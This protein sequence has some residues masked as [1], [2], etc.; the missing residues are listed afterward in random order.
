[1]KE[2]YNA[3]IKQEFLASKDMNIAKNILTIF[4]SS[5]SLESYLQKDLFDFNYNEYITF[6]EKSSYV[7]ASKIA[8]AKSIIK[9]YIKWAS[10]KYYCSGNSIIEIE[11]VKNSDISGYYMS[12]SKYFRD[13]D[14][15]LNCIQDI[16]SYT[17]GDETTYEP[18][19]L[20]YGLYWYGMTNEDIYTLRPEQ[21]DYNNCRIA[22]RSANTNLHNDYIYV[23]KRFI[24]IAKRVSEQ[25]YTIG[26][27]G[28]AR[29]YSYSCYVFRS[30][31]K[32]Q[33]Y[34]AIDGNFHIIKNKLWRKIMEDVP[35]T[36]KFYGKVLS[37]TSISR[38][39][40]FY[41]LYQMEKDGTKIDLDL[42]KKEVLSDDMSEAAVKSKITFC[43]NRLVDY[44]KWKDYCNI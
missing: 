34:I 30:T 5:S 27:D 25:E 40:F 15:L 19:Q 20:F 29:Y 4:N 26:I 44:Q 13:I 7:L 16:Y 32:T 28:R 42:M 43:S 1:M 18:V 9:D 14:E 37:T 6:L 35:I 31:V 36:D 41:R 3:K 10:S 8:S 22:P 23:S 24:E 33:Q 11:R 2:L 38:C 21:I 12:I 39:G 17:S